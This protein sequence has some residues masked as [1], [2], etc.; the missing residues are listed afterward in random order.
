MHE[1]F[2]IRTT[3]LATVGSMCLLFA[4]AGA[5]VLQQMSGVM[6]DMEEAHEQVIAWHETSRVAKDMTKIDSDKM[7]QTYNDAFR[8]A[9]RDFYRAVTLSGFVIVLILGVAIGL[10]YYLRR[11]VTLP[12]KRLHA[13]LRRLAQ[14]DL[15]VSLQGNGRGGNEIDEACMMLHNA[16]DTLNDSLREFTHATETLAT[17]AHELSGAT[18]ELST[19]SQEQASSLEETAA[20]MEEMTSTVKHN[21]DHALE[22]DQLAAESRSAADEG[23][24]VAE[25]IKQSMDHINDSSK[26]IADIIGVINDIA[27][28]TNL[29]A[30][31]AA[32]E[33]ARAGEHGH[34][35]AVVAAEVRNLAQRSATAAKEIKELIHDSLDIVGDGTHLVSISGSKLGAIAEKV[36]RVAK[37]ISE[38][39]VASQEQASGIEQVNRTIVQ[40]D[41]LTQSNAAQVEE[42][43]S[44]SKSLAWQ[45]GQLRRTISRFTLKSES[46][47]SS[48]GLPEVN[49]SK[50][51]VPDASYQGVHQENLGT[52]EAANDQ[53]GG[54]RKKNVEVLKPRRTLQAKLAKHDD[55][56]EF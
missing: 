4:I 40:M 27:F 15:T 52:L 21:A 50:S 28:Q 20:S 24:V 26:K 48:S 9:E 17:G 35:F 42:L 22:V 23:L 12:L 6:G 10:A 38:I 14:G 7:I 41:T 32:V 46:S 34:G 56:T 5:I 45:A 11:K 1:G 33:A 19:S 39:S 47:S 16:V 37:L 44:T 2:R 18:E 49:S 53:L 3:L 29:L 25:S 13:T 51:M 55:W 36:Q 43:T 8:K 31:N 54:T 30:L